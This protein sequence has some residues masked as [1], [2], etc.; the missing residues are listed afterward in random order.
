MVMVNAGIATVPRGVMRTIGRDINRAGERAAADQ[1]FNMLRAK[2]T[3]T[4]SA[5]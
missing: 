5:A 3:P 2:C 1:R 4:F